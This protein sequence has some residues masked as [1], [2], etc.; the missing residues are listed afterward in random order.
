MLIIRYKP[1]FGAT[2]QKGKLMHSGETIPKR[3]SAGLIMR[4]AM[5]VALVGVMA[6]LRPAPAPAAEDVTIFSAHLPPYAMKGEAKNGFV[7]EVAQEMARR[8]GASDELVFKPWGRVYRQIQSGPKSL[9]APIART[10][11]REDKLKWVAPVYPDR[12]AV[13][14]YGDHGESIT[15]EEAAKRGPVAVQKDSL[16]HELAKKRGI[17]NLEVTAN[18]DS[19]ARKVAVGR[20]KY[21]LSLESLATYSL[22]GEGYDPE[23]LVVGEVINEF[24]VYIGAS[25][26]L[27]EDELQPWREAFDAMKADGTYDAIMADYG[28][29]GSS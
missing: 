24:T 10:E 8:V 27:T 23:K 19:I 26:D 9:L 20:I 16:M 7:A 11:Q 21:W 12:M 15:L 5:L 1:R 29:D 4:A 3:R 6:P 2:E 14:S 13:F 22:E 28:F 17:E 18:L 25:P